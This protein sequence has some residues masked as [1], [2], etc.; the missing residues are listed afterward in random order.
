MFGLIVFL[1]GSL[2]FIILSRR[3]IKE[4]HSY[5]FPRFF[6]F[7]AI[8]G[9]VVLNAGEWFSQPFS[10]HQIISWV[11]L[12]ASAYMAIY[13]FQRLHTQGAPADID[14]DAGKQSFEKTT[15][16][17]TTGPYHLIRHP[18]YAS[19]L[20]LA[21]GVTLKQVNLI[22]IL[23]AVIASL[24]LLLTAVYEE[25]ENLVKFGDEYATYIKHSKRFIPYI[26]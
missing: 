25:R 5:G 1:L 6:A 19:L 11:L 3:A 20:Y 24:T 26:F 7:E 15:R 23:L 12:L 2:G 17:V 14:Q 4:H 21:W 22:S 10:L 8:L 13:S 18:L 16:L 9:L